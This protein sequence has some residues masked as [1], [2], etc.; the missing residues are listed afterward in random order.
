MLIIMYAFRYFF[1]LTWCN[2]YY[3]KILKIHDSIRFIIKY[4]YIL[5]II[6]IFFYNFFAFNYTEP[7]ININLLAVL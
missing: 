6:Y 7:E 1:L 4:R 2:F 3:Y 5:L